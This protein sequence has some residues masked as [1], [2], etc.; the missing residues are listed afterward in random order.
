[1]N[2]AAKEA[3]PVAEGIEM[4]IPSRLLARFEAVQ[5]ELRAAY[6][7]S[8]EVPA[9][10]CFWLTCSTVSRIRKEFEAAVLEMNE[11][12]IPPDDE[13]ENDGDEL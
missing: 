4:M 1:V 3:P 13:T 8:P 12:V 5:R 9:L 11:D 10:I 2:A 6:G 7:H